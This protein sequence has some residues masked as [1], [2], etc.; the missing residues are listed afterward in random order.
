[1]LISISGKS[2]L[3]LTLLRLLEVESGFIKVDGVDIRDIPHAFVRRRAFITVSQDVFLLRDASLRFNLDPYSEA[4][5]SLLVDL[6][7]RTGLWSHFAHLEPPILEGVHNGTGDI[8]QEHAFKLLEQPLVA[9]PSLS[10]GQSQLLSLTRSLVQIK[11]ASGLPGSSV[12][13][14]DTPRGKPI[15]LLDEVTASLDPVTESNMY[16]IIEEEIINHGHTVIMV[17]HKLGA[18]AQRMRPEKDIVVWMKD[19]KVGKIGGAQDI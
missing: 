17:T 11:I 12:A 4:P 19:G 13:Y 3:L 10:V 8:I 16:D 9:L 14:S 15:V 6:L 1:M 18:F 2:S 5:E 7:R